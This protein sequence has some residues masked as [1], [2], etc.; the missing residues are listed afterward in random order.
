MTR[1]AIAEAAAEVAMMA[2]EAAG[3]ALASGASEL[4]VIVAG[5]AVAAMSRMQ[6]RLIQQHGV[7]HAAWLVRSVLERE[8]AVVVT[9]TETE[10]IEE[11]SG[12]GIEPRATR[13]D[14]DAAH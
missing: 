4:D 3:E 9:R 14:D 6:R 10:L 11:I 13:E 7:V 5:K 1:H 8:C 2:T 12:W